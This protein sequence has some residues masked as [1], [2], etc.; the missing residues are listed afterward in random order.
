MQHGHAD[1]LDHHRWN[2]RQHDR[3]ILERQLRR[4]AAQAQNGDESRAEQQPNCHDGGRQHHAEHER[5]VG[6]PPRHH[7]V[8]R[9]DES[10]DHGRL[11]NRHR[12]KQAGEKTE[13]VSDQRDRGQILRPGQE[14]PSQP[15]VAEPHHHVEQL[16]GEHR[17]SQASARVESFP[18]R[19]IEAGR[20]IEMTN[21]EARRVALASES[22]A[23]PLRRRGCP[24]ASVGLAGTGRLRLP[25][26][27]DRFA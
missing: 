10:G 27:P 3:Q 18:A 15:L 22:A 23:D 26:P 14:V 16:P 8:A 4:L 21:D 1:L 2:D 20:C 5:L 12:R 7:D 24:A 11:L 9:P 6:R 25:V 17:Q 13:D 19:E